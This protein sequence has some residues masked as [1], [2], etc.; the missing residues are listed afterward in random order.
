MRYTEMYPWPVV[1]AILARARNKSSCLDRRQGMN[2]SNGGKDRTER[3]KICHFAEVAEALDVFEERLIQ[4][5]RCIA[6]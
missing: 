6:E 4:F 3:K 5:S 1:Y 2:K